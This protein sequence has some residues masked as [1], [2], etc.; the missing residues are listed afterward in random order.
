MMIFFFQLISYIG[1]HIVGERSNFLMSSE[2]CA[3]ITFQIIGNHKSTNEQTSEMIKM[4]NVPCKKMGRIQN[5]F[6]DFVCLLF[7]EK[8]FLA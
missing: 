5:D 4:S 6:C 7:R 8:D 3:N 2:V 1:F